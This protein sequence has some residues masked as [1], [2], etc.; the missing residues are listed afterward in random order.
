MK[1]KQL[2]N[3]LESIRKES[4]LSMQSK[5]RIRMEYILDKAGE[6]CKYAKGFLFD[7]PGVTGIIP[8]TSP[9]TIP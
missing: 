2:V 8:I 6:I 5:N 4:M 3:K 1:C 7:N 9:L